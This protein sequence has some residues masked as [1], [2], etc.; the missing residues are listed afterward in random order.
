[1]NDPLPK[2]AAAPLHP[3]WRDVVVA[4]PAAIAEIKAGVVFKPDVDETLR[5][6]GVI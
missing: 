3:D 1:M 6:R 4:I 5:R 2:P